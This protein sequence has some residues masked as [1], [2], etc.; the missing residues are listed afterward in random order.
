MYMNTINQL[1]NKNNCLDIG[2][3]AGQLLFPLA[4]Y[5]KKLKGIDLDEKIL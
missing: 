3:G 1:K 2:V 4:P 5:F